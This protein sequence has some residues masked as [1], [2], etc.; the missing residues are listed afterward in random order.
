M[1]GDFR[2]GKHHKQLVFLCQRAP[3][4]LIELLVA[5]GLPEEL[6]KR[7]PARLSL[8]TAGVVSVS[9]EVLIQLPEALGEGL[10]EV[11]MVSKAWHQFLVM[12]VFMDPAQRKLCRQPVE[13][14]RVVAE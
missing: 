3:F 4:A 5:A 13:L 14:G 9:Q 7:S 2:M 12:A 1:Q 11:A 6:I 10:Q 8:G